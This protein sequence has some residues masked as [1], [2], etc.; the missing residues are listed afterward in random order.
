M[1]KESAKNKGIPFLLFFAD[2]AT[3][4][5]TGIGSVARNKTKV[6]PPTAF[7]NIDVANTVNKANV[8]I[9]KVPMNK[10]NLELLHSY[11]G[12]LSI[13]APK[14][15]YVCAP[16]GQPIA[17]LA[18]QSLNRENTLTLLRAM[19]AIYNT[20]KTSHPKAPEFPIEK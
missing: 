14:V 13:D 12:A 9:V 8:L 6:P 1:A 20:W 2:E 15:L 11:Q 3:C 4:Q 10:S 16:T 7:D 18:G 17:A 5:S 19:G